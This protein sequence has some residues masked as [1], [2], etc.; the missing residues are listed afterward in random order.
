MSDASAS[1]TRSPDVAVEPSVHIDAVAESDPATNL[2]DRKD[3]DEVQRGYD[4]KGAVDAV[5]RSHHADSGLDVSEDVDEE[6]EGECFTRDVSACGELILL[7][8][9]V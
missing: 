4:Y 2:A 7:A 5:H 9:S 1:R 6:E 3:S 8:C